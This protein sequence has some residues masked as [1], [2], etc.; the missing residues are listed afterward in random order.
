MPHSTAESIRNKIKKIN[1]QLGELAV[2]KTAL[3][4]ELL[5]VAPDGWV[6]SVSEK[7]I[8]VYPI[9]RKDGNAEVPHVYVCGHH[10]SLDLERSYLCVML[11]YGSMIVPVGEH[12]V[13]FNQC[14]EPVGKVALF[15]N[16]EAAEEFAKKE[17]KAAPEKAL[18]L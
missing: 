3:Y 12:R 6:V 14:G 7:S 2:Q 5:K 18:S 9:L 17:H 11:H 8:A 15:L 16:R 4:K 13:F 10:A 1:I